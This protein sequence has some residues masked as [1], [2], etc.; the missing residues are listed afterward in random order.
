MPNQH[1]RRVLHDDVPKPPA[2]V[3]WSQVPCPDLSYLRT[4]DWSFACDC[5][6]RVSVSQ[7][8]SPDDKKAPIAC[9]HDDIASV[10]PVSCKDLGA[11]TNAF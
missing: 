1:Q 8:S 7:Q 9:P 2:F 4:A 10:E 3:T 11:K 5:R 6:I